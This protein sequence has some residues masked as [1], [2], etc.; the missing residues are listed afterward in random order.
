MNLPALFLG[1]IL[2]VLCGLLFHVLR[3][4]GLSRL[5]LYIV[6]AWV[7]FFVGQLVS[8]WLGWHIMRFGTL[9]LFPALLATT[10]GLIT[11]G[12]LAGPET[13]TRQHPRARRSR[14]KKE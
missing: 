5:L 7:S 1:S 6:T 10:I 9:N 8:N 13:T 3:G 4:G 11:A 12:V 2:A 14:R